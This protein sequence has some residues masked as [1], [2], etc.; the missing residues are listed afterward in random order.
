MITIGRIFSRISGESRRLRGSIFR[1]SF[2]IEPDT[3][4]LDL[5]S[6]DGSA[7]AAILEGTRASP[8]TFGSPTSTDR[9]CLRGAGD[10]GFTR[11]S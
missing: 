5:G 11:S 3:R 1:N 6:E 9:C 8:E 10:T 2:R 7:V 4:I